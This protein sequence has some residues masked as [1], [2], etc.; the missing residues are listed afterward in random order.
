MTAP[1][2]IENMK[3]KKIAGEVIRNKSFSCQFIPLAART[4]KIF[5]HSTESINAGLSE[6]YP[7]FLI[8]KMHLN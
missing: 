6:N 2:Q 1:T 8:S 3:K 5:P 7:H 4:Q